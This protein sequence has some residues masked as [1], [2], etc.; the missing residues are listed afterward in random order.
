MS[1]AEPGMGIQFENL[2][3]EARELVLRFIQKR[4][5]MFYDV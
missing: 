3:A 2:S 4:P 1:E 5:P